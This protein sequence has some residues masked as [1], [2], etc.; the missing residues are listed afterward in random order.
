MT[1]ASFKTV[2][3]SS[4]AHS[5]DKS[6]YDIPLT[7][8]FRFNGQPHD[9]PDS[10]YPDLGPNYHFRNDADGERLTYAKTDPFW[11]QAGKLDNGFGVHINYNDYNPKQFNYRL[12]GG[13][14]HWMPCPIFKSISFF[15]KRTNNE[16]TPWYVR[17]VGL[18]LKNW[19]TNEEK[20]WAGNFDNYEFKTG[21]YKITGDVNLVRDMGP[22]WF[23]Y[24]IIFN[25]AKNGNSSAYY[26]P[27]SFLADCRL[28]YQCSGLDSSKHNLA[29]GK[30]MG[31][32]ALKAAMQDGQMMF[33]PVST[34]VEC[35]PDQNA[36]NEARREALEHRNFC[37]IGCETDYCMSKCIEIYNNN[38]WW[39]ETVFLCKDPDR[40]KPE[41]WK[42]DGNPYT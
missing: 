40:E 5:T 29:L 26:K 3:C 4:Y 23:V 35:V 18:I 12:Y 27:S 13:K 16:E 19:R 15:W 31:W 38:I 37:N 28:G 22:D 14:G 41:G 42:P 17:H 34:P 2:P 10:F 6:H 32:N 39:A 11:P 9:Y 24:G 7:P 1:D 25:M 33:E 30:V 8:W 36:F 20:V 21:L